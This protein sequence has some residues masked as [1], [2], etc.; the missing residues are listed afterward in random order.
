LFTPKQISELLEI[1]DKQNLIFI[2]SKLGLNYLTEDEISRLQKWGISPYH[3]YKDSQDI[4]KMSFHFG[5]ISDAIGRKESKDIT[6]DDL[7][8]Y[9]EKGE[10][11]PLTKVER[12]TIDSIKKQYLG[13]IRANNG[14][15][16]QDLNN[17]I[18]KGEK[19]NRAAY[20]KVIRDEIEKGVLMKKTSSEIARDLARKTGDWNR[21]FKRIVEF[22]SHQAWDEGRAASIENKYGEDALVA[23]NV[24]LGAC[25]YCISAYLTSGIGS[26][27]KIFKLSVLKANGSNIG[28]KAVD[29]KPV[30]GNHHPACRCTL[31]KVDNQ[32]SW[33]E[34]NQGFNIPKINPPKPQELKPNRKLIRISIKGKEYS[35]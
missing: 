22:I 13:D 26:Q 5:L 9:F 16:F 19:N 1:L 25:K 34:K 33:D 17:I 8:E 6:L 20:E 29:Y 11:I 23:K 21:N 27:P 28:R 3:L 30:I 15:I 2:S 31:F 4:A 18:A 35:V 14:K 7:K 12:N 32:F 24:Y 10:H